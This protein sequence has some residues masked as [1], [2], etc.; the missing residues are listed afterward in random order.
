MNWATNINGGDLGYMFRTQKP[1]TLHDLDEL[2]HGVC[3]LEVAER[4]D[5]CELHIEGIALQQ[6]LDGLFGPGVLGDGGVFL[7]QPK[8]GLDGLLVGVDVILKSCCSLRCSPYL[9]TGF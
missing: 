4:S 2:I 3:D 9:C 1:R 7:R 5:R 8:D 6:L